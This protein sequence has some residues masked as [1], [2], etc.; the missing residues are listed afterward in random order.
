M[1]NQ[2]AHDELTEQFKIYKEI[3]T[4]R[5]SRMVFVDEL[6]ERYF[7][8]NGKIPP[9]VIL[10]RA[11]TLI[12]LDELS[13]KHPDKMSRNE[14]PLLSDRQQKRRYKNEVIT[15]YNGEDDDNTSGI[16]ARGNLYLAQDGRSYR[17]PV[18]KT[19]DIGELIHRDMKNALKI[20]GKR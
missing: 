2:Y 18:R 1:L 15:D 6:I 12:L 10:D 5:I 4:S 8:E 19:L 17:M 16:S 13:D 9:P 3:Q 14:Y 20:N 11:A 7:S